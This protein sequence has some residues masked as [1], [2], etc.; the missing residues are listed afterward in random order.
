MR[1]PTYTLGGLASPFLEFILQRSNL[2]AGSTPNPYYLQPPNRHR[3]GL[4]STVKIFL[5]EPLLAFTPLSD[6]VYSLLDLPPLFSKV[7]SEFPLRL[8]WG[9]R[10]T[11]KLLSA[12]NNFQTL[13]FTSRIPLFEEAKVR[14]TIIYTHFVSGSFKYCV[15]RTGGKP[16]NVFTVL[17]CCDGLKSSLR[18]IHFCETTASLYN[19]M[20]DGTF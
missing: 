15:Y 20:L 14:K 9:G 19:C 13:R 5:R 16:D 18:P 7:E 4:N 2:D 3:G 8:A 6:I 17:L 11:S 10:S 12:K 1:K